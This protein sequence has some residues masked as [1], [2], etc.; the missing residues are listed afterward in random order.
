M[1]SL[2]E[3]LGWEAIRYEEPFAGGQFGIKVEVITEGIAAAAALHF[4]RPV[5]YV[6]SL[7][8][9]MLDHVEAAPVRHGDPARRRTPTAG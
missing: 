4:R 6:P 3:A 7:A 8:E 2:Q 1:A 9:S 5:R